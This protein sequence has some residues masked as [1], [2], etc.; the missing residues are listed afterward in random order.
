[1][2]VTFLCPGARVAAV[3]EHAVYGDRVAPS[4]REQEGTKTAGLLCPMLTSGSH[5]L[6]RNVVAS[7]GALPEAVSC[8]CVSS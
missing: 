6:P 2:L 5:Q 1:M 8:C 4:W 7:P 3:R